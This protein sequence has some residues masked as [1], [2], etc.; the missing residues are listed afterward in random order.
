[1]WTYFWVKGVE[2]V[3]K[4]RRGCR[5]QR[6]RGLHVRVKREASASKAQKK[7]RRK[8]KDKMLR[9]KELCEGWPGEDVYP[10]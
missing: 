5:R 6:W 2:A 1:M 10:A 3:G 4:N 8:N 9:A 7:R